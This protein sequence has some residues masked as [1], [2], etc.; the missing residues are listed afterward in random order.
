MSLV[1]R[2]LNVK[3]ESAAPSMTGKSLSS[4]TWPA[5]VSST[6]MSSASESRAAPDR[7]LTTTRPVAVVAFG[8]GDV[9][10]QLD[11]IVAGGLDAIH[12]ET[13]AAERGDQPSGT[14]AT[15]KST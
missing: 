11:R 4:E 9:E 15:D 12:D 2:T 1:R 7:A 3:V 5:A 14:S 6:R 13:L 10:R 8:D